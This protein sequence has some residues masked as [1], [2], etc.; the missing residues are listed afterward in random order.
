MAKPCPKPCKACPFRRDSAKGWLGAYDG[1][2]HFIDAHYRAEVV[3]PCH[4]TVDYDND[5]WEDRAAEAPQCVGQMVMFRNSLKLPRRWKLP[6]D[7]KHDPNVFS[8]PDEFI[9]HHGGDN[10]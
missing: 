5:D 7:V 8:W 3:N 4:M 9:R 2:E 10:D 6:D 1:P